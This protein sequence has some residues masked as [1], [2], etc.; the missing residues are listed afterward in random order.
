MTDDANLSDK[1]CFSFGRRLW[2]NARTHAAAVCLAALVTTPLK[3]QSD[4]EISQPSDVDTPPVVAA[5]VY[6]DVDSPDGRRTFSGVHVK[7]GWVLTSA[8][9]VDRAFSRQMSVRTNASAFR[10][11]QVA[12]RDK[13]GGL[14]LLHAP[15]L[16]GAET[17]ELAQLA[18]GI[19]SSVTALWLQEGAPAVRNGQMTALTAKGDFAS[20]DIGVAG[21]GFGGALVNGCGDLVGILI[22][23]SRTSGSAAA[24]ATQVGSAASRSAGIGTVAALRSELAEILADNE[25]EIRLATA[26][27]DQPGWFTI[28][29]GA[30]SEGDVEPAG[31]SDWIN[32]DAPPVD[33]EQANQEQ[34]DALEKERDEAQRQADEIQAE[35]DK[36]REEAAREGA[37]SDE[38]I[39]GL[40]Q[41]LKEAQDDVDNAARELDEATAEHL[42]IQ[43]EAAGREAAL[44]QQRLYGAIAAGVVLVLGGGLAVFLITRSRRRAAQADAEREVMAASEHRRATA[45]DWTLIGKNRRLKLP[46]ELLADPEKGAV[47]GRSAQEADVLLESE[48][49]SRR[50]ARFYLVDDRLH[51]EDLKS[52]NGTS[53]N[54]RRL[55]PGEAVELRPGDTIEIAGESFAARGL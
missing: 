10:S 28:A 9:A 33:D 43:E 42:R 25:L 53:V 17:V 48:K 23:Q 51:V 22:P 47:L 44:R 50:H 27:C 35:L 49:T 12:E 7:N 13:K 8:K 39:Q 30:Q 37:Q 11:F 29:G 19:G 46:G 31:Q 20:H 41:S 16:E 5:L 26:V 52:L 45:P 36:A 40:E 3:A 55:Q 32:P 15:S 18:P 2:T 14:A 1:A 34:L 6:V 21:A 54:G 24:A 4:I 38:A